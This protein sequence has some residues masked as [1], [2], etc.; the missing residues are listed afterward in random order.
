[1]VSN[2]VKAVKQ[3]N[4]LVIGSRYIGNGGMVNVPFWRIFTS[5]FA[6]FF[7]F[8]FNMFDIKDKTSGYRAYSQLV[9]KVSI[10]TKGFPVQLEILVKIKN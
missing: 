2:F 3:G 1:M 4:D 5:K 8:I 6:G 10:Q 7:S 9:K